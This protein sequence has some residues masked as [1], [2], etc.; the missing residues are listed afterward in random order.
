MMKSSPIFKRKVTPEAAV[1]ILKKRG[2]EISLNDAQ[3]ILDLLYE[4][5]KLEV[6]H[7][8]KR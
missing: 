5:A 2:L 1:E 6:N 8:L 7:Y 3:R 4:L